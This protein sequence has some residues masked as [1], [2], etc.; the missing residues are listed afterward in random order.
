MWQE[1]GFLLISLYLSQVWF[2]NRRAKWRKQMLDKLNADKYNFQP[3]RTFHSA[4]P[5]FNS[6]SCS[7]IMCETPKQLQKQALDF[8]CDQWLC[9]KIDDTR[10]EYSRPL[11]AAPCCFR[12]TTNDNNTSAFHP[13][14]IWIYRFF[15][16]SN[17]DIRSFFNHRLENESFR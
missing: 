17:V 16:Q 8:T 4:C 7:C 5:I 9:C 12:K 2:Q 1:C 11:C 3:E 6:K 14:D 15:L 10:P 13:H